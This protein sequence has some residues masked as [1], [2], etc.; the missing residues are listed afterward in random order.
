MTSL[1]ELYKSFEA[2]LSPQ[3]LSWN[4]YGAGL[5]NIGRNGKPENYPFPLPDMNQLLV[6]QQ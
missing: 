1:F 3:N 5:Q 6:V 4:M 2:Q